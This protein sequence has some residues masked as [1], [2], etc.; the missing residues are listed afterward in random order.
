[1]DIPSLIGN[2]AAVLTTVSFIPQA[3]QT[4]RTRNTRG[5]SLPMYSMLVTGV[6][7]WFF[8]GCMMQATPIILANAVTFVF[9][10][11]ILGYK[12]MEP[13]DPQ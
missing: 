4:I 6:V 2:T 5:I 9:S 13:K 12:I 1:M 3:I 7:L 11:I 8:Y 10:A